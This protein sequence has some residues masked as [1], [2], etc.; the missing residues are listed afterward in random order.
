MSL[1]PSHIISSEP[2]WAELTAMRWD[3]MRFVSTM[4][5]PFDD[6]TAQ[7]A[8]MRF[9]SSL[10]ASPPSVTRAFP[11]AVARTWN[12]LPQHIT[13][14]SSLYH[15]S[16][17]VWTPTSSHS[18]FNVR[19]AAAEGGGLKWKGSLN[20]RINAWIAGKALCSLVTVGDK[21]KRRQTRTATTL[22]RYN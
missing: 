2:G 13:P 11:V 12:S 3:E 6:T 15:P 22:S 17:R 9:R 7:Y 5:T 20:L 8:T 4:W 14:A 19:K 21:L 1:S 10:R 18:R 16:K